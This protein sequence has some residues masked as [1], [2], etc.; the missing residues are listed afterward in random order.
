LQYVN[1]SVFQP[2]N[3][4][5][6]FSKNSFCSQWSPAMAVRALAVVSLVSLFVFRKV[7]IFQ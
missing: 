7:L 5:T 2:K 6:I 1:F 4:S 3:A